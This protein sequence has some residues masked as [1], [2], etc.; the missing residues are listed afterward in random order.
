LN[1]QHKRSVQ[2]KTAIILFLSL[3]AQHMKMNMQLE[4]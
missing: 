4:K 3:L 2:S 1:K